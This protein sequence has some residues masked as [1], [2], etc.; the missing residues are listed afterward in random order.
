MNKEKEWNLKSRFYFN[1]AQFIS[2]YILTV[3]INHHLILFSGTFLWL[4]LVNIICIPVAI[5]VV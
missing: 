5:G 3:L 2:C 4:Y 1:L